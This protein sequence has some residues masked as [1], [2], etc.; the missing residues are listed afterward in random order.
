MKINQNIEKKILRYLQDYLTKN[1]SGTVK[2]IIENYSAKPT[3]TESEIRQVIFDA[4]ANGFLGIS[5]FNGESRDQSRVYLVER[6][7]SNKDDVGVKIVISKPRLRELGLINIQ[8]RNDQIDT[9][10]CFQTLIESSVDIIRICSPFM[11]SDVTDEDAFPELTSCMS[12][13]FNRNVKVKILTRDLK[14][15]GD[16]EIAW[17]RNLAKYLKKENNLSIVD[18]HLLNDTG[19]ILS[20]THAKLI[21]SDDKMAY[22]GSAELRKNSLIANFEVGCLVCGPQVTGLCEIFDTM[23]S[24]GTIWK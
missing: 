18:Y 5:N 9:I 2:E 4:V 16:R 12:N 1:E 19:K 23:Y 6:I 10:D 13:A 14:T 3:I 11:Q 15:R 20:S 8:Q 22:V 24:K 17:I 21:I 7:P